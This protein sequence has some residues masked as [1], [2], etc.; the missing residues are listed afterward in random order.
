MTTSNLMSLPVD[1]PW[2]RLAFSPD[3]F[4]TDYNDVNLPPKW[5]SSLAAFY[6][7]VPEEDTADVYPDQKVVYIKVSCTITGFNFNEELERAT[8]LAEVAV[9][10]ALQQ[11]VW[12]ALNA[13]GGWGGWAERYLP[14]HG[15]IL[16]VAIYPHGDA[17]NVSLWEYPYIA[18]F[19]PK[20][21]EMY[22]TRTETGEVLSGSTDELNIK[23][24]NTSTESME[25]SDILTGQEGSASV[26]FG[27]ASA[28]GK[29]TGEWGTRKKTA[30]EQTNISQANTSQQR[31]ETL[32]AT[33]TL[34]QMYQLFTGYHLGTNRALFFVLPR[35]HTTEDKETINPN[36]IYGLR[37]LEGIQE[38]FLVVVM[39]KNAP[40][41]CFQANLD[42]A[43]PNSGID[44]PNLLMTRRRIQSC[45][46]FTNRVVVMDID[47]IGLGQLAWFQKFGLAPAVGLIRLPSP[48]PTFPASVL[49]QPTAQHQLAN[50]FNRFLHGEVLDAMLQAYTRSAEPLRPIWESEP[51]RLAV[52]KAL[53]E[54]ALT[55][56]R[57]ADLGYMP[58]SQAQRW[59]RLGLRRIGDFFAAEQLAQA[60][61]RAARD[62]I[63]KR[64]MSAFRGRPVD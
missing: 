37:K 64:V 50:A 6:H 19:E 26:F 32:S 2:K 7:L 29:R 33:T 46:R 48:I 23:K 12:E 24:G 63:L 52:A 22:E 44:A 30:T 4:D 60:E 54:S 25:E 34:S 57:L 47:K 13:T 9:G 43:H 45:A 31:R 15:A 62:A 56:S 39:P 14:C 8:R 27:L 1:I 17:G 5:R 41:F 10:D 28:S 61:V 58:Q 38:V 59:S 21:R 16:Q 40:G 36:L 20:K 49:E 53:R 42:T 18:D 3:M 35:P 51:V 55:T 11:S